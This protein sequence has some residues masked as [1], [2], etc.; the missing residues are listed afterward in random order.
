MAGTGFTKISALNAG[1]YFI[2]S[3]A[4]SNTVLKT[5]IIKYL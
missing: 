4:D 2:V 3:K 1:Y 5:G